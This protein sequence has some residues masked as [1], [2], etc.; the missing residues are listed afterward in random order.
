MD[1]LEKAGLASRSPH[2]TDR[3]TTLATITPDGRDV[4]ERA[5]RVLNELRFGT[6]PMADPELRTLVDLLE[7]MRVAA[8][9]FTPPSGGR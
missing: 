6:E 9:D 2:P 7:R 1:G 5:T 8:G 3:R 4:A